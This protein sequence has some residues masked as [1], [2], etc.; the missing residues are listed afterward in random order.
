MRAH[1]QNFGKGGAFSE[2]FTFGDCCC[3]CMTFTKKCVNY[4]FLFTSWLCGCSIYMLCSIHPKTPLHYCLYTYAGR[5]SLFCKFNLVLLFL[6]CFE[7]SKM[8]VCESMRISL[9]INMHGVIQS[10]CVCTSECVC[11]CAFLY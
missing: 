1:N 4:L 10:K 5:S 11:V 3:C 7:L 6:L 8:V 2:Y 9:F